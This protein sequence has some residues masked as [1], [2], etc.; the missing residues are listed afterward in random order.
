MVQEAFVLITPVVSTCYWGFRQFCYWKTNTVG[1]FSEWTRQL[2]FIWRFLEIRAYSWYSSD[3]KY[4]RMQS[5]APP[6]SAGRALIGPCF[7]PPRKVFWVRGFQD[8]LRLELR[9]ATLLFKEL[10]CKL[11]AFQSIICKVILKRNPHLD[12]RETGGKQC[13]LMD[14]SLFGVF[15]SVMLRYNRTTPSCS[16]KISISIGKSE[17][18]VSLFN[19]HWQTNDWQMIN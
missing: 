1:P 2:G 17:K 18:K 14:G 8:G 7:C 3:R 4:N 6:R 11:C 16:L 19:Q 10:L 9:D 12:V 15:A 5:L 13:G